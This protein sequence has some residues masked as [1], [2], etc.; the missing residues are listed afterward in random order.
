MSVPHGGA[1]ASAS[2]L[3]SP[4]AAPSAAQQQPEP[5]EPTSDSSPADEP[6]SH[7]IVVRP[8]TEAPPQRAEDRGGAL[9]I[10]VLLIVVGGIGTIAALAVR[11]SR[12]RRDRT[13]TRA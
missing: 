7:D 4:G 9:Q 10:A 13:A 3:A 2:A 5:D 6:A 1:S 11:E 12:R 8:D